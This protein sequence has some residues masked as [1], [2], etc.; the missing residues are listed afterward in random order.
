MVLKNL[1]SPRRLVVI[2]AFAIIAMSV[3]GFAAAN[4]VD[5][6]TA[7]DGTGDVTGGTASNI[8]YELNTNGRIS[9]VHFDYA[10][11]AGGPAPTEAFIELL[12]ING[13]GLGSASCVAGVGAWDFDCTLG[14]S[15]DVAPVVDLRVV[16][17]G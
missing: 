5:P 6:S 3:F 13:N 2:A 17:A 11:A 14:G 8:H 12:D 1:K 9:S 7:G 16:T 10:P 4:T 15:V